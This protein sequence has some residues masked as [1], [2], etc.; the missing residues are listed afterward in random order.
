MAKPRSEAAIGKPA[1]LAEAA[2]PLDWGTA[3]SLPLLQRGVTQTIFHIGRLGEALRCGELTLGFLNEIIDDRDLIRQIE[4][5][6]APVSTWGTKKF[7]SVFDFRLYR[8]AL[9][10]IIRAI[11]PKVAIETGVLHGLTSAF[12]LRALELNGHG[13]LISID[14]PSY[15][16]E[17]PSNKDGYNAVLPAGKEPGWTVPPSLHGHWDLRLGTSRDVLA[18][19]DGKVDGLGFFCHDSEHTFPTMWFEMNWAWERLVP[20]GVLICDNAEA[21]TSFVEFARRVDRF[22][23]LFPAPDSR[24]NEPPRFGLLQK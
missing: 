18:D 4:L 12:L 3:L 11:Q 16:A 5:Q 1:G 21:N 13:K 19:L 10:A 2:T 6:V 17:G 20:G 8:I 23:M 7:D 14:L 24:V 9:Y 22:P 15:P